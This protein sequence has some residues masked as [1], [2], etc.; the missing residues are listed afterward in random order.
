M[1][2]HKAL[3]RILLADDIPEVRKRAENLL[4]PDFAVIASVDD[5]EQA[6]EYALR[7][8]S[9][10]LLLDICMPVSTE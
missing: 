2:D 9:E 4:T 3:P 1:K 8:K 5:V 7:L 10:I 6:I